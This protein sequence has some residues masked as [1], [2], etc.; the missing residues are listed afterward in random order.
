MTS[1]LTH[2]EIV[3]QAHEIV[4][5]WELASRDDPILAMNNIAA[6][7]SRADG[8]ATECTALDVL[9]S[10]EVALQDGHQAGDVLDENSPLRDAMR[11]VLTRANSMPVR[12][13]K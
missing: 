9:L 2:T 10:I 4:E 5:E 7:L 11:T 8:A 3:R 1:Q 6:L 12:S 13:Q